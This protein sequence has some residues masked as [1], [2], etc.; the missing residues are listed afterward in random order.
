MSRGHAARQGDGLS[1]VSRAVPAR[2]SRRRHKKYWLV[3][4]GDG[5]FLGAYATDI[6]A[7]N[8]CPTLG[9][10]TLGVLPAEA[11]AE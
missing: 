1:Y 11:R 10:V 3:F 7:W 6:Q 5:A 8:N 2:P 4:D 9:T